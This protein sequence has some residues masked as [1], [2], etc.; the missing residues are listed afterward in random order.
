MIGE[1]VTFGVL[2]RLWN[3]R[4]RRRRGGVYTLSNIASTY[5]NILREVQKFRHHFTFWMSL[6][7]N[8]CRW[9]PQVANVWRP[10]RIWAIPTATSSL[11]L[12]ST[13]LSGYRSVES[14]S[15]D[16]QF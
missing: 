16:G 6:F 4:R 9:V 2:W 5:W 11:G 15:K 8:E 7:F 13:A 1:L 12:T 14:G 3:I 10:G